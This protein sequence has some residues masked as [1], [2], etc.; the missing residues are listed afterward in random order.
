ME[1]FP[2]KFNNISTKD[3]SSFQKIKKKFLNLY[4]AGGNSDLAYHAFRNKKN[5][6]SKREPNPL[7]PACPNPV[8]PPPPWTPPSTQRQ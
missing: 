5:K 1:K 7:V 4:S 6:Y 2:K 8:P 3:V